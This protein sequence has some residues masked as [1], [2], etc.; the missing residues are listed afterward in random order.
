V[1][2]F[3]RILLAPVMLMIVVLAESY[4]FVLAFYAWLKDYRGW[5]GGFPAF[6]RALRRDAL[7][8]WRP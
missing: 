8:E 1:S 3:K 6:Y 7:R 5:E 2:R 4:A